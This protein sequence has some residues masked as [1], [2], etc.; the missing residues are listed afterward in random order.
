MKSPAISFRTSAKES[1]VH[2]TFLRISAYFGMYVLRISAYFSIKR[3][4]ISANDEFQKKFSARILQRY[5]KKC[6]QYESLRIPIFE[7]NLL[8]IHYFQRKHKEKHTFPL[9]IETFLLYLQRNLIKD[10]S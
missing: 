3:L 5:F 10:A 1:A 8:K 4:R 6:S 9:V 7:S 2:L